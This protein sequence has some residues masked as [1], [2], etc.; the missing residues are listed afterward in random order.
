VDGVLTN[1][2]TAKM[3]DPT[4]TY[5]IKRNDTDAVVVADGTN[6]TNVSTGVYEYSFEDIQDIAYTAYVEFVY[7]SSTFHF[8]IDIPARAETGTMVA[9]YSML[10]DRVGH[11][12]YGI[13][14]GFD[15]VQLDCIEECIRDG[16]HDVYTAHPWSFFRPIAEI[17][18]TAPYT[19]GTITVVAGVVTLAGGTWPTWAAV[20]VLRIG[21]NYYDVDSR[22]TATQI[23]LEDV[24]VTAAA[25][26]TYELGREEYDLPAAFEAISPDSALTYEPGQSDFYPALVQRHDSR[27]RGL[28][29]GDPY[30]DRPLFYSVR[31]ALF[32]PTVGSRKRL[33]LYPTPDAAYVLKVP[34]I[35]RPTMVDETNQYPVGGET[36]TQVIIEACL[37]A[38]ERN[39]DEES[40][41]HT[42]R[43]MLMLPLAIRADLEKSSPTHLGRDVGDGYGCGWDYETA[44][45]SRIGTI[46]LDSDIL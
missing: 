30:Y 10:T 3:S 21:D 22:D 9:S 44:R 36:L 12:L 23:T 6:M 20:G 29:Q 14:T 45:A 11:F 42:E 4:G 28:H 15:S 40:K 41:R 38:A 31:T 13:R 1:V 16:L 24:T 39:Y 32:D 27:G 19:T 46:T 5:G 35:L 43:F 2:T 7:A 33:A 37:A 26:T 17:T 34:M 25:L 18:T 8:E